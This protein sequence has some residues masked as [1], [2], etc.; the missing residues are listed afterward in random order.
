[1]GNCCITK[2]DQ[3]AKYRSEIVETWTPGNVHYMN[4]VV[5]VMQYLPAEEAMKMQV[6]CRLWYEF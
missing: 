3:H 6:A 4:W 2:V 1:M 5:L